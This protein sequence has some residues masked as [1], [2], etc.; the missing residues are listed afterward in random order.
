MNRPSENP[1]ISVVVPVFRSAPLLPKLVERLRIALDGQLC[2]WEIVLV[3]D[4]SLDDSYAVMQRLRAS[5]ARVRE[6]K[7]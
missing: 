4:A 2:A 7:A 6:T 5:D 1:S 3:D